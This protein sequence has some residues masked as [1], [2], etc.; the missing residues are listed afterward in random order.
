MDQ[1]VT[2]TGKPVPAWPAVREWLSGRGFAV[3]MRMIDGQLAFPDEE[4]PEEW[5]EIRV[6]TPQGMVTLRRERD[7]VVFVT[8]GNADEAMRQGW[9]ALAWAFASL[10][11]GQVRTA[12]GSLDAATFQEQADLPPA[13]RASETGEG[14]P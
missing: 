10:G 9:N 1:T 12:I 3:Q 13:L 4:P 6:G 7:Q 5:R 14:K 8:W 2:F 11:G